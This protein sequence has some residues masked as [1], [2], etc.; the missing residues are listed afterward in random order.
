[1]RISLYSDLVIRQSSGEAGGCCV[2]DTG[3]YNLVLL[4]TSIILNPVS[5]TQIAMRVAKLKTPGGGDE[6]QIK[7]ESIIDISIT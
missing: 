1:M 6:S 2:L 5:K 3:K 7:S 4:K